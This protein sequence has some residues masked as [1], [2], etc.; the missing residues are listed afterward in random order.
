MPIPEPVIYAPANP[1]DLQRSLLALPDN[2]A[3]VAECFDGDTTYTGFGVTRQEAYEVLVALYAKHH[4][5]EGCTIDNQIT[6]A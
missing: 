1:T 3:W 2:V 6:L 5:G 4:P